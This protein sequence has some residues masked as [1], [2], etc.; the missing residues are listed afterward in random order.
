LGSWFASKVALKE[1]V[2]LQEM[3]NAVAWAVVV[4][5]VGAHLAAVIFYTPERITEDPLILLKIWDGISSYGGF[6]GAFFGLFIYYRSQGKPWLHQA[7]IC[8]Q[9]LV[10]GWIFG[11]MACFIAYDH[12]GAPTDF[13]LAQEYR[14]GVVR[15]NLGFYEFLYT[16]LVIAPVMFYLRTKDLKPGVMSLALVGLYAP[17]RFMFDF[18]RATDLQSSDDRYFGLT[19]AQ[20]AC[21]GMFVVAFYAM[22][23]GADRMRPSEKF[24]AAREAEEKLKAQTKKPKKK[25]KK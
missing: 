8:L 1:G 13:F 20:Y 25:K 21:I 7:E 6:I 11:R 10:L 4:G 23:R 16:L 3:R 22:K 24:A 14:D 17:V 19:F 5:F 12:P 2:D 15:H 9:A 18:L